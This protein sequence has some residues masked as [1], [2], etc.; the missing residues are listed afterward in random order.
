MAWLSGE[1]VTSRDRC[2]YGETGAGRHSSEHRGHQCG[3]VTHSSGWNNTLS[4]RTDHT[5]QHEGVPSTSHAGQGDNITQCTTGRGGEASKVSRFEFARRP[6]SGESCTG[7]RECDLWKIARLPRSGPE[8]GGSNTPAT[9]AATKKPPMS[10]QKQ[11]GHVGGT[12]QRLVRMKGGKKTSIFDG[13]AAE[14]DAL[15]QEAWQKG[16]PDPKLGNVR[17]YDF[18]RR[19][20]T[21]EHGGGQS[22]VRVT[23]DSRGRIHGHP[24]GKE[25]P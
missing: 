24:T 6:V 3:T 5:A 13:P 15:T 11:A 25:T 10:K 2:G 21:G 19:I 18:G 14:A 22:K 17:E 8:Q 9:T 16:T 12:P 20:G 7:E 1:R 23:Q 4:S